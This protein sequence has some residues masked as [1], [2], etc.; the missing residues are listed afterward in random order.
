[1]FAYLSEAKSPPKKASTAPPV[2]PGGT[3]VAL[4]PA[5]A[6]AVGRTGAPAG[7]PI[8]ASA[9]AGAVPGQSAPA[10]PSPVGSALPSS[11]PSASA[12]AGASNSAGAAGAA[13]PAGTA[14]AA[15][16]GGPLP[17]PPL[18]G[19]VRVASTAAIQIDSNG[20]SLT[21]GPSP[22]T[23]GNS[24]MP[25][26]APL[27]TTPADVPYL[28]QPRAVLLAQPEGPLGPNLMNGPRPQQGVVG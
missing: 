12:P 9:P 11:T 16:G 13:P 3:G 21:A 18:P 22:W 17:L 27:P 2:P 8:A 24:E 5:G 23:T 19:Q 6:G 10:A 15:G 14:G 20:T 25:I 7:A 1:M 28:E 4:G 26:T